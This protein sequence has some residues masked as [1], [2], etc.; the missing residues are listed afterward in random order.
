MS[1]ISGSCGYWRFLGIGVFGWV[2]FLGSYGWIRYPNSVVV[3]ENPLAIFGLGELFFCR[4]ISCIPR[5]LRH[6]KMDQV[7]IP[8]AHFGFV[9]HSLFFFSFSPE[10]LFYLLH[11]RPN[12]AFHSLTHPQ[13]NPPSALPI[14]PPKTT[15]LPSHRHTPA[16][17]SIYLH[18]TSPLPPSQPHLPSP[19]LP[20][21][22]KP[23]HIPPLTSATISRL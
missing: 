15:T 19:N 17:L 21:V 3:L 14:H 12:R 9:L 5:S 22:P 4:C 23:L 16:S 6:V 10:G 13:Q 1:E 20:P 7:S 11:I 18:P 8:K 2:N